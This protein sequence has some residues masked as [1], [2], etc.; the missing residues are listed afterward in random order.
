MPH[1]LIRV[2]AP[3]RQLPSSNSPSCCT[4]A[5][6]LSPGLVLCHEQLPR[7]DQQMRLQDTQRQLLMDYTP[8]GFKINITHTEI[9]VS[10]GQAQK[11]PC[12]GG[13]SFSLT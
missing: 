10:R 4:E 11:G 2:Q 12:K 5:R 7:A 6:P 13:C 3:G 9:H 8:T 1:N